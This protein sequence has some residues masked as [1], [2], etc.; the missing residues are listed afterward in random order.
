MK[1][2]YSCENLEWNSDT[3][4]PPFFSIKKNL[5]KK[6]DEW[7]NR[8]SSVNKNNT[9]KNIFNI[10][11]VMPWIGN[12]PTCLF[13]SVVFFPFFLSCFHT[14]IFILWH[15]PTAYIY[16]YTSSC[17]CNQPIYPFPSIEKLWLGLFCQ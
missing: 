11:R 5:Y 12:K 4:C 7:Y 1:L 17:E 2:R 16:V 14:N 10:I 3:F 13:W 15:F 6:E 9:K 8:I